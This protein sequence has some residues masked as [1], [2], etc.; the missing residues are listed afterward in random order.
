MAMQ[1]CGDT[2]VHPGAAPSVGIRD[3][4]PLDR[5]S[6]CHG[7]SIP[8]GQ[9]TDV[10][11]AEPGTIRGDGSS[12]HPF[13]CPGLALAGAGVGLLLETQQKGDNKRLEA[14]VASRGTNG[15]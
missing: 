7:K 14:A 15:C 2:E 10:G 8:W 4:G 9:N 1:D 5:R 3:A 13:G 11:C 6:S 12:S